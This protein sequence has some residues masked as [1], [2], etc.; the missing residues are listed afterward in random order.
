MPLQKR[1]RRD[2]LTH[3][4]LYTQKL[5]HTDCFSENHRSFYAEK[6]LRTGAFT[7]RRLYLHTKA[8]TLVQT[9]AFTYRSFYTEKPLHTDAFP[10]RK[11]ISTE[12][13]FALFY[14]LQNVNFYQSF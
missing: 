11:S 12:Q 8:C 13:L 5:S 6:L 14:T 4:R 10:H 3:T 9:E 7:H 1:L 2:A